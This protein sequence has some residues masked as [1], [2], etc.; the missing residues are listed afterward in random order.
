LDPRW[1]ERHRQGA[2]AA[3]DPTAIET[4]EGLSR[5]PE[6]TGSESGDAIVMLTSGSTA[7]PKAAIL[8]MA[9]VEA[10]AQMTSDALGVDPARHRWLAC[11]PCAHIG[12]LSVITR[13]ILT[14]TPFDII[15]RSDAAQIEAI[16]RQGVTHVSLVATTL[17]RIDPTVFDLI[18]LGGS[19][20]PADIPS[21]V[22]TTYGMTETGSGIVYDGLPLRG[23]EIFIA[24][25]D[26][27]GFGEILVKTPTALRSYRNSDAPFLTGPDGEQ[28][29]STGDLGRLAGGR[30]EV[31]G[32]MAEVIVSGGEKIYP[33]DVEA[34]ISVLPGVGEVAVWKRPDPEWGERVV[35]WI[36]PTGTPPT[37][38]E[39]KDAVTGAIAAWAAPKEIEIVEA[40]PRTS[41]G[42]IRRKALDEHS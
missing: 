20:P 29:L 33:T 39:V 42:K 23:V 15:E 35:A 24:A 36:V 6:G 41:I 3:I 4:V 27:G 18:L 13:A 19:A 21:N 9:A 17:R 10:S 32:R 26:E 38:R 30:L 25:E 12:G 31:R 22:V 16:G 11:L 34:A 14:S 37:L 5:L 8:T 40:L 7:T 2:L 1:S 28:W